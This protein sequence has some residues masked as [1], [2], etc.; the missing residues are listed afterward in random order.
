MC[1]ALYHE[2]NY[3]VK[4]TLLLNKIFMFQITRDLGVLISTTFSIT[5]NKER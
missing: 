4:G 3:V 2:I 1:L 5:V